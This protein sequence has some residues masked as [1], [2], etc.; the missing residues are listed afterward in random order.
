MKLGWIIFGI[1]LL[2]VGSLVFLYYLLSQG[3]I[4]GF[5]LFLLLFGIIVVVAQIL[6]LARRKATEKRGR[7][8]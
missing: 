3:A 5:S 8:P 6:L 4:L 7:F 1:V 2:L